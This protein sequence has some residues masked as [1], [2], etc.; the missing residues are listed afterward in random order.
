MIFT[1]FFLFLPFLQILMSVNWGHMH[2]IPMETVLTQTA[3][4]TVHVEKALKE[5]DLIAQVYSWT[6]LFI[7]S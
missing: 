3:A 1:Y 7:E 2:A 5:M 6:L 4:L